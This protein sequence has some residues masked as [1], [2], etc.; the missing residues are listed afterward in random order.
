MVDPTKSSGDLVRSD[1][2][3]VRVGES[4]IRF[5]KIS[6]DEPRWRGGTSLASVGIISLK[7]EIDT[8]PNI[9]GF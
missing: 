2:I 8:Q 9:C 4:F 1:E 6:N 7:G 5:G 3:F